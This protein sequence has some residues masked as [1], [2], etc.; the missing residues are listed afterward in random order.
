MNTTNHVLPL[1]FL[2]PA[3]ARSRVAPEAHPSFRAAPM[4]LVP[5]DASGAAAVVAFRREFAALPSAGRRPV[6]VA[7]PGDLALQAAMT[8]ALAGLPL[9]PSRRIDMRWEIV[10]VS[11]PG[12]AA[13]DVGALLRQ[14]AA[15]S[16]WPLR[17]TWLIDGS[18]LCRPW[19]DPVAAGSWEAVP[20][21]LR[22][23]EHDVD[24][25][26]L[27]WNGGYLTG[28]VN[29]FG[30]V[31]AEGFTPL[32]L[33][34]LLL[35]LAASDLPDWLSTLPAAEDGGGSAARMSAI[36]V[37]S[38]WHPPLP[39]REQAVAVQAHRRA[40]S[41]ATDCR[42]G[43]P[44]RFNRWLATQVDHE[45]QTSALAD[46]L[47]GHLLLYLEVQGGDRGE[48][49]RDLI[50]R[51]TERAAQCLEPLR[52]AIEQAAEALFLELGRRLGSVGQDLVLRGGTAAF[53]NT[54][55][56]LDGRLAVLRDAA[57]QHQAGVQELLHVDGRLLAELLAAAHGGAV[58]LGRARPTFFLVRWWQKWRR[59]R[60]LGRTARALFRVLE[61]ELRCAIDAALLRFAERAGDLVRRQGAALRRF[62]AD[63][64]AVGQDWRQ[65]ARRAFAPPVPTDVAAV[66]FA[67]VERW[68][69]ELL[70]PVAEPPAEP[71][72]DGLPW[73]EWERDRLRQALHDRAEEDA[74]SQRGRYREG[75]QA[76]GQAADPGQRNA[77]GR[78]SQPL[79]P[80]AGW[81]Y[82][83]HPQHVFQRW[84]V[85]EEQDG[86]D[87]AVPG[88]QIPVR[89]A[90]PWPMTITVYRDLPLAALG[91]EDGPGVAPVRGPGQAVWSEIGSQGSSA[92][93]PDAADVT[94]NEG[95][96]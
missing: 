75:L 64:D 79:V 73:H 65:Q 25:P 36:G 10:L 60:W 47:L 49:C 71:L 90:V 19:S 9:D 4:L 24:R 84:L 8:E 3:A 40:R 61:S 59:R 80:V 30:Y 33:S 41:Y 28:S 82:D 94:V 27:A 62:Q 44:V 52:P 31:G 11:G 54:L 29:R 43:T 58:G 18:A 15:H 63:L 87:A 5:L 38:F 51:A 93:R 26:G 67:V 72:G 53:G 55:A 68:V 14:A 2:Q 32:Y 13:T 81:A 70:G 78:L 34:R 21:E 76:C 39:W 20:A 85:P 46:R 35:A 66:P 88:G 50:A 69:E 7:A 56:C 45:R 22:E 1:L 17:V 92:S 23:L 48:Q 74:R 77:L 95:P 96:P 86:R 16:R 83:A 57:A 12:P 42:L 91:D 89:C 37:S 6:G